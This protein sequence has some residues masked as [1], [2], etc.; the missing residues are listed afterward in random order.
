MVLEKNVTNSMDRKGK[1]MWGLKKWILKN[2]QG[3][4]EVEVKNIDRKSNKE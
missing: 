2:Q 4:P 3:Y 1:T